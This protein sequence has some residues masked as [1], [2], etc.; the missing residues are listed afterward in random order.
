MCIRD[1]TSALEQMESDRRIIQI[2]IGREIRY[3]AAEDA[4]RFRDALGVMPPPGLPDAFMESVADPIDDL[5][6]RY[7]RT[8][9]P[10]QLEDV[11]SRFEIG[12]SVIRDALHRLAA[13]DRILE[14]EFLPGGRGRE[15]CD[16]E[17]LRTLKRK[18][19]ARLRKQIE[20]VSYTALARFL[21]TWQSITNRR[22]G[23]DGLLDVVEQLQGIALPASTLEQE[24]LPARVDNFKVSDLDELCSAGEIVWR[25][26][27]KSG[28]GD[29]RVGLYL[30]DNYLTLAQY[31]EEV[32]GELHA[33]IR[34]LLAERGASFFD[35]IAKTIGGFPNDTLNALWDLVWAGEIT[36]DTLAPL[37]SL[38]RDKKKTKSG[39]R[40]TT[41]MRSR[42]FRSR[43]AAKSPGAEGRWSLLIPLGTEL[44]SSTE[45]QTALAAQMIERYGVLTREMVASE[46]IVGSFSGIYPI[47]KAMEEAGKV[48]RGYF[49]AGLGAAQFAAP[50][51]EDRLRD[52]ERPKDDDD[53]DDGLLVLAATDPANPYGSAI[54]WPATKHGTRPQRV[55]GAKVITHCG[56]LLGYVGRNGSS[57]TTFLPD[58]DPDRAEAIDQ[59][60][61]SFRRW[62]DEGEVVYLTKVDGGSPSDSEIHDALIEVGFVPS[63]KGYLLRAIKR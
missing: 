61:N 51:A 37:R 44:P 43:R 62:S 38:R 42:A 30:A 50:G 33:Q 9:V 17:V 40:G 25:G 22:R 27:D 15:W 21:P 14:G 3:A 20:P 45:K 26:F 55:A 28:P 39:S 34:E 54:K 59:L 12:K 16:A 19:L 49:V 53:D 13:K 47:L 8:H 57:L 2:R 32:E 46:G 5:V 41:R 1:R 58:A 29:G 23:L 6:S 52:M 24:I 60:M 35:D 36:N 18:S 4:A 48:R 7:A 11:A 63:V 31:I 56:E 10:F